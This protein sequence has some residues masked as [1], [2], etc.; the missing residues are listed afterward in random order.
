M[1]FGQFCK[2]S[3]GETAD[4]GL[5]LGYIEMFSEQSRVLNIVGRGR[6]LGGQYL[7]DLVN[8]KSGKGKFFNLYLHSVE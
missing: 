6:L 4:Y 5:L 7:M 3:T 8:L 1:S 2:R